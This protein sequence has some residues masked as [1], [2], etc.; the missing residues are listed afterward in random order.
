MRD[1]SIGHVM[2]TPQKIAEIFDSSLPEHVIVMLCGHVEKS[3]L[4]SELVLEQLRGI[5]KNVTEKKIDP[6]K[7]F[8]LLNEGV[9][10]NWLFECSY[11]PKAKTKFDAVA[12]YSARLKAQGFTIDDIAGLI[13]STR[14][15]VRVRYY[16]DNDV[17]F[18]I[19]PEEARLNILQGTYGDK[20]YVVFLGYQKRLT[21]IEYTLLDFLNEN[22]NESA[23]TLEEKYQRMVD[24]STA[25]LSL[26]G[27]KREVPAVD[28][29]PLQAAGFFSQEQSVATKRPSQ[30]RRV[31]FDEASIASTSSHTEPQSVGSL[32]LQQVTLKTSVGTPALWGVA[33]DPAFNAAPAMS[34]DPNTPFGMLHHGNRLC[35]VPLPLPMGMPQ[36]DATSQAPSQEMGTLSSVPFSSV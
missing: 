17:L 35:W 27:Q 15:E 30:K 29:S 8:E 9:T 19:L 22:L 7:C 4:N 12:S 34:F 14:G 3:S 33:S 25:K 2:I 28:S 21:A 16:M 13:R 36:Y 11:D 5:Q 32:P 26:K 1:F 20:C 18:S 6:I 31:H 23:T 24:L 10:L